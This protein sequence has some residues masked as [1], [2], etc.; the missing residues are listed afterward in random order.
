MLLELLQ[1]LFNKLGII[2]LIAFFL[3]RSTFMKGYLIKEK[4][5]PLDQ[6]GIAIIFGIL[7][8]IGTY[9]GV[10]VNGAIAN[11][12]SIGVIVAGLYG[13]P[14]V[15]ITAGLI[16]GIHRMVIPTGRFTA[17]ACGLSTIIGG[18]IAG[19]AKPVMYRQK[20]KWLFAAGLT[21]IIEAIQMS[22]I[23]LIARPF[24]AAYNLVQIIFVPMA[25]INSFGTGIFILLIQQIHEENER[26]AAVKAGL[27][28]EIASKTLPILRKGSIINPQMQHVKSSI[29][30]A[31]LMLFP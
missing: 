18:I 9:S 12:R 29:R 28:L 30:T 1:S 31:R 23:L 17:I 22:M 13:G 4:M 20:Q 24:E 19:Y 26:S 15:G 14:F 3:S 6:I 16:A 10:P 27:A 8:I 25:F 21:I 7:G 2:V 11:S 5:T